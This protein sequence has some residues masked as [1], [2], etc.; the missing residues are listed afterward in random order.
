L[1]ALPRKIFYPFLFPGGLIWAA[2]ILLFLYGN[3]AI[4]SHPVVSWLPII[5][6]LLSLFIG[7]RFNRGKLPLV[8]LLVYA[9]SYLL[10][11]SQSLLGGDLNATIS[12]LLPLNYALLAFGSE[13]GFFSL[14]LL[15]K[16]S[17]IVLQAG[18]V[19]LLH[20]VLGGD[21][22]SYI[23]FSPVAHPIFDGIWMPQLG[24]AAF[25][26][27]A[28]LMLLRF[29]ARKTAVDAALFWGIVSLFSGMI[30]GGAPLFFSAAALLL[31][32]GLVEGFH[33]LAF[34][35]ELTSLPTRRA[36]NETLLSC[37]A[38]TTVAIADID[39]FKRVNDR[40]GHDV[41]DQ[42]L[43]M[44]SSRLSRVGGGGRAFRYGGEEFALIFHGSKGESAKDEL[45]ELRAAI[46][47]TPFVLRG[48][49]RPI[50]SSSSRNR[51]KKN[52]RPLR[53][54]ISIGFSEVREGDQSPVDA[55]TRADKALYKS[56]KGGRNRVTGG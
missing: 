43:K 27:T 31:L 37:K 19:L 55:V 44:V 2:A 18:A 45:E 15:L 1:S 56:K 41:G 28:V 52:P 14:A 9:A 49:L 16:A 22:H 25:L 42:V 39:H 11:E 12:I 54:T 20:R 21:F 53:V 6:L 47:S 17:F 29:L 26:A 36:F 35:D 13:R 48:I 23:A 32:A 51:S 46:S 34:R 8:I 30:Y 7:W 40:Y 24:L 10:A 3:G 33:F 4:V 38:P 5:V 50:S